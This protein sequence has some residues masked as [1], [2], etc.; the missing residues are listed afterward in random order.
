MLPTMTELQGWKSFARNDRVAGLEE[1]A[2]DDGDAELEDFAHDKIIA[3][4]K[5]ACN[6]G[7]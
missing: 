6:D 3:G 5:S 7:V 4:S 2:H 1:F